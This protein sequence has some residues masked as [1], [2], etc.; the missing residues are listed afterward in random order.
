MITSKICSEKLLNSNLS[1]VSIL[2]SSLRAGITIDIFINLISRDFMCWIYHTIKLLP[3]TYL[4]RVLP[5]V[6]SEQKIFYPTLG[7]EGWFSSEQP[8]VYAGQRLDG[9]AVSRVFTGV[10]LKKG[11]VITEIN[12][13]IVGVDTMWYDTNQVLK[14]KVWRN[15]KILEMDAKVLSTS[16]FFRGKIS[17]ITAC[18][19]TG[20]F[21]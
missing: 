18:L 13:Q 1:I 9:F 20:F 19:K 6:L 17:K 15:G 3:I 11:D 16:W 12:G 5:R 2:S 21:L 10:N 14:L 7:V 8:L 4:A